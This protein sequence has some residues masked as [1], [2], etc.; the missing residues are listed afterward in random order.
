GWLLDASWPGEISAIE[1][2]ARRDAAFENFDSHEEVVLWFEHD[3]YDQLQLIQILDRLR[4]RT[5]AGARAR[6]VTRLSLIC[7]DRYL[8]GLTGAQLAALW[9]ARRA[10]TPG[11]LELAAAAWR[12]FRSPDPEEIEKLLHRDTSGLPFL[13]GALWRHLQ[14]FP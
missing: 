13:D 5:G 14:Q 10:V 6:G 1:E 7:I 9:P 8:G 3:L 11:E 2:L 4:A 12:A